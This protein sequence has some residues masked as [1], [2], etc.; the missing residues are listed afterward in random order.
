MDRPT[1]SATPTPAGDPRMITISGVM[2][3]ALVSFL[4]QETRGRFGSSHANLADFLPCISRLAL[5][6]I[7]N[8]DALYHDIEYSMLVTL[9]GAG[10]AAPRPLDPAAAL[11]PDASDQNRWASEAIQPPQ[12]R[13]LSSWSYRL[14]RRSS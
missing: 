14:H 9:V 8:S 5:E 7:G 2:A 12:A 11:S 3:Q 1:P 13:P 6:Y 10:V 4:A